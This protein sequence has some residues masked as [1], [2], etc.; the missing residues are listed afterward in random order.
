MAIEFNNLLPDSFTKVETHEL[1]LINLNFF[2]LQEDYFA[3]NRL[4]LLD[5]LDEYHNHVKDENNSMT[6]FEVFSRF[7]MEH[8]IPK[9]LGNPSFMLEVIK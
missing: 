3:K 4:E 6:P 1:T 8:R 7:Y 2:E 9:D 5:M